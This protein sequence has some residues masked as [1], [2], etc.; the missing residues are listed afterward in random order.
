VSLGLNQRW[1]QNRI[2]CIETEKN[3]PPVIRKVTRNVKPL[4]LKGK[5]ITDRAKIEGLVWCIGDSNSVYWLAI[6]R[7][8]LK[9]AIAIRDKAI[10][11][12]GVSIFW[13]HF[14]KKIPRMVSICILDD[15]H[16]D[17]AYRIF[18]LGNR[19]FF[20]K[21][22]FLNRLMSRF[23]LRL[24][25]KKSLW[26]FLSFYVICPQYNLWLHRIYENVV[27]LWP[28]FCSQRSS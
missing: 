9:V 8:L 19:R 27:F 4:Q 23:R 22:A 7:W 14:Q 28:T 25:R 12:R 15:M 10:K 26:H 3:H 24:Q 2:E 13:Q 11:Q 5:C 16:Q 20:F 6:R 21:E 17:G 1:A 18:V